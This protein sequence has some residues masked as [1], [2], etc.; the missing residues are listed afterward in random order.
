MSVPPPIKGGRTIT[1]GTNIYFLGGVNKNFCPVRILAKKVWDWAPAKVG[2]PNIQVF[3]QLRISPETNS[4][5][6]FQ[7]ECSLKMHVDAKVS[8]V[9]AFL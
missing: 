8:E 2:H 9:L 6:L 1:M 3:E 5:A 7:I 4:N